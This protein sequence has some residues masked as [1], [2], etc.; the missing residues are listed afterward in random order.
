M[1]FVSSATKPPYHHGDLKNALTDAAIELA[2]ADGPEQITVRAVAKRV[3]VTPTAAYRHFAGHD[4]LVQAVKDRAMG[5]LAE[6]IEKALAAVD[7]TEDVVARLA[8]AGTG[9]CSFAIAEPGLFLTAFCRG[10]SELTD[11]LD[12]QLHE[13]EPYRLLVDVVD[14]LIQA[15]LADESERTIIE[16]SAWSSVHGLSMLLI[17]GPLRLIP[18]DAKIELI[19]EVVAFNSRRWAGR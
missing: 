1:Q 5:A 2:A 14:E 8:A 15:G 12:S 7:P 16:T 9:Y 13:H 6:S 17:D 3:G 19:Q 4:D 10:D 18:D 11:P